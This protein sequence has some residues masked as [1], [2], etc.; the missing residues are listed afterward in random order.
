MQDPI[1]EGTPGRID[2]SDAITL[3][4]GVTILLGSLAL[5][6]AGIW[7]LPQELKVWI[8]GG[9]AATVFGEKMYKAM[10]K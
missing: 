7:M 10:R 5:D 9:A 2:L 8:V 6:A 1:D 3:I 4:I